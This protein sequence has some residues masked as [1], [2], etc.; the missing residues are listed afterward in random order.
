MLHKILIPLDG[1]EAAEQALTLGLQIAQRAQAL[2]IMVRSVE[3]EQALVQDS[4]VMGGYS[5]VW[6]NQSLAL[7][8]KR[9]AAYLKSVSEHKIPA[10][11]PVRREILEEAPAE[12]IV[13]MAHSSTVD[14]IVMPAQEYLHSGLPGLGDVARRVL[15]YAPCPVLVVRSSQPIQHIMIPLDGS[16]LSENVLSM[17]IEIAGLLQCKVTLL[18]VIR[19]VTTREVDAPETLQHGKRIKSEN[20][21]HVTVK[22]YLDQIAT[23]FSVNVAEIQ[24]VVLQGSPARTILDYASREGV[25]LIAMSTHGRTGLKRWIYGSVTEEILHS[26][27]HCSTLVVRPPDSRLT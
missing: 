5:P 23:K 21:S 19:P 4:H 14:L 18:R 25:D 27:E 6:P 9:A 20:E 1:S 3:P 15:H 24:T 11:L 13:K 10:D 22:A 16:P 26:T 17:A 2:I 8:H 7:A 12:A